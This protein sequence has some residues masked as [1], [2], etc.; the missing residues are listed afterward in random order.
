MFGLAVICWAVWKA[1]NSVCF[2][3]KHIN[4]PIEILFSACSFIHYWAG[5]YL[6]IT[7]NMIEAGVNMM[8]KTT[9]QMIK[10]ES[11]HAA[12]MLMTRGMELGNEYGV[13]DLEDEA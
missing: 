2:E 5:L 8:M 12:P 10:K 13:A 7:K 3:K 4:N 9:F 1:R 6:E 11:R